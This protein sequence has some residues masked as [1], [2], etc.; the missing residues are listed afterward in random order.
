MADHQPVALAQSLSI[1]P[2]KDQL[3]RQADE[4]LF[5]SS[6]GIF[7]DCHANPLSPRQV[8]IAFTT[9]YRA[10]NLP[11]GSLRE[12]ILLDPISFPEQELQSGDCLYTEDA[13]LK[14]RLTFKC[15]P[16]GR[17]NKVQPNL[18]RNI[19]GRRGYLARVVGSGVLRPGDSLRLKQGLYPTFA[20]DW[21]E[22][23][24]SIAR[25]LPENPA[26]SY[27]HLAILAGVATGYCRAFPRLLEAHNLP[28]ERIVPSSI[29]PKPLPEWSGEELFAPEHLFHP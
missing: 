6:F 8:L 17:L 21:H 19:R 28:T 22:R 12:N 26:I 27:S 9:D 14:L 16:C 25:Q 11:D 29:S 3:P 13:E 1:R 15:E 24:I 10:F 4:L 5:Q 20:E 7:G 23:V 18:S 2:Y